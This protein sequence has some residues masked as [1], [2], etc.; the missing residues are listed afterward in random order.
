MKALTSSDDSKASAEEGPAAATAHLQH[1]PPIC[2]AMSFYDTYP[3]QDPPGRLHRPVVLLQSR[4][5]EVYSDT[6]CLSLP[7][8]VTAQS[9][10]HTPGCWL[11]SE[12]S[13]LL[14]AQATLSHAGMLLTAEW[15]SSEQAD[16]LAQQLLGLWKEQG[17]GGPVCFTWTDWLQN[18]ALPFLGVTDTLLLTFDSHAVPAAEVSEASLAAGE[19][20]LKLSQSSQQASEPIAGS[21]PSADSLPSN[22]SAS[23]SLPYSIACQT[24]PGSAHMAKIS[25]ADSRQHADTPSADSV[26]TA[27]GKPALQTGSGGEPGSQSSASHLVAR[28]PGRRKLRGRPQTSSAKGLDPSAAAWQPQDGLEGSSLPKLAPDQQRRHGSQKQGPEASEPAKQVLSAAAAATAS[29]ATAHLNGGAK[30]PENASSMQKGAKNGGGGYVET[31]PANS[32][33]AGSSAAG[34][35][36]PVSS[37]SDLERVVQLYMHLTAYSKSRE[38]ELFQ[39]ASPVLCSPHFLWAA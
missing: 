27:S 20:R 36:Q 32:Q 17:P 18:D 30:L 10:H 29:P 31:E 25:H 24:A 38:R 4:L 39:E 9:V 26:S 8:H 28:R 1:L 35:S 7:K 22:G 5:A 2:L 37:R 16:S 19:H 3:Q 34:A 6:P 33:A 13:S 21:K 15:L 14:T 12:Q 23:Q 11:I